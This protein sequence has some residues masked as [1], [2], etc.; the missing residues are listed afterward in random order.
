MKKNNV[1]DILQFFLV[2]SIIIEMNTL[3]LR[4]DGIRTYLSEI[5]CLITNIILIL[6]KKKKKSIKKSSIVKLI[7]YYIMIFILIINSNKKGIKTVII[8][9]I[10]SF[11]LLYIYLLNVKYYELMSIFSK[12]IKIIFFITLLAL[13]FWFFSA[14]VPIMK[15]TGKVFYEWGIEKSTNTILYLF[16]TPQMVE[17]NGKVIPRNSG[18]FLEPSFLAYVINVAIILKL[19]EKNN[20]KLNQIDFL[21]Y[22]TFI[23]TMCTTNSSGGISMMVI[24]LFLNYIFSKSKRTKMNFE[25]I[26]KILLIPFI[27]MIVI[28]ILTNILNNKI[29]SN[30]SYNH[31][32][33]D[34]K[35]S[36]N[37]FLESP[38][39]GLGINH[40]SVGE[41][42][43][44][45]GYGYSNSFVRVISDGGIILLMFYI[46]SPIELIIK[47]IKYKNNKFWILGIYILISTFIVITCYKLI[48][49]FLIALGYA[50]SKNM[51]EI[52]DKEK[53]KVDYK[54]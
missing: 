24:M 28:I 14:I 26:I 36:I 8:Y 39:Y 54:Q 46:I 43:L 48:A 16:F 31:R 52:N 37:K 47:S 34:Y 49:M 40:N 4:I 10:L 29:E 20:K 44:E 50:F 6:L 19:I 13:F 41:D 25:N 15:F 11:T 5:I 2:L 27:T 35:N 18:I 21:E 1:V 51:I 3:Y 42:D 32:I 38:I 12:F 53:I 17:Y 45:N 7:P 22:I 23:L 30:Y 33:I 9:Y